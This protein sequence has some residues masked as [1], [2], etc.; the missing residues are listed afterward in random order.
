[1][2]PDSVKTPGR[3]QWRG[4]LALAW[5]DFLHEW[6]I[7]LCLIFAVSAVLAPLLVLFGLRS[8]IVT[9]LSERL[10]R[11]P[12]NRELVMRGH[13]V[14]PPEW[15][16]AMGRDEAVGFVLPR[17]RRLSATMTLEHGDAGS[18]QDVDMVPTAAGDP[19]LPAG[20]PV[21]TGLHD[22]LL[23]S[24]AAARLHAESGT[25]LQGLVTRQLDGSPQ[26]V[27]VPL[28]VAGVLPETAFGRD[29]V[30]VPLGLLVAVEDYRD[31]LAVAELGVADGQN[32]RPA[33]RPFASA[34]L[35]AR[36]LDDVAPLA[37]RLRGQGIE[38]VTRAHEIENVKAI[39]RVLTLIFVV[40]A[41]IAVTG[42]LLSLA[43]SL[44]ANVDRKRRDI[45]LLRLL[46]LRAGPVIGFPAVQALLVAIGGLALSGLAY[47]AV[48]AVFNRAF[49][50]QLARDELVCALQPRHAVY[51]VGLTLLFALI[52]SIV[53]GYR[54]VRIDPADSLRE[55]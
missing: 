15:F 44:W 1:M 39:D 47:L 9:T 29:A 25:A 27:R 24:T 20:T 31:G 40:L 17:T 22:V 18:L 23:T 6:Q 30:F 13:H 52:A 11:D 33:T 43:A 37:E 38:V 54:A 10:Q 12:V 45:A 4:A 48:A 26:A 42:A 16:A 19:L 46:G 28:T 2:Q 49:A 7:S 55:V 5:R 32:N 14:L 3:E 50:T 36:D 53:G 34:R 8:G 35:Y 41:A 21:P 51:A